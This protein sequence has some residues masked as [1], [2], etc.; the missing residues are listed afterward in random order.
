MGFLPGSTHF[1]GAR[2]TNPIPERL[3]AIG[4]SGEAG[5]EFVFL[6]A[7]IVFLGARSDFLS[8]E[9]GRRI[10]TCRSEPA[11]EFR[12]RENRIRQGAKGF[13]DSEK[14]SR[15]PEIR[16]ADRRAT[17][18]AGKSNSAARS[19]FRPLSEPN[20]AI[21]IPR[22]GPEPSAPPFEIGTLRQAGGVIPGAGVDRLLYARSSDLAYNRDRSRRLTREFQFG[23][24]SSIV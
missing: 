6:I 20:S 15:H 7:A 11:E 18:E 3:G 23:E 16:F 12:R 2:T 10:K 14:R 17:K 13:S 22:I 24:I 19:P 5:V 9:F 21:S 8:A 4:K 1:P